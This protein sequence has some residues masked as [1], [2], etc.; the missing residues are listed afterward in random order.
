[1]VADE[2]EHWPE[3]KS[4]RASHVRP[5]SVNLISQST[6]EPLKTSEH[7]SSMHTDCTERDLEGMEAGKEPIV[8]S[9][10]DITPREEKPSAIW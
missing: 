1:M 7:S 6:R 10:R 8:S 5:R 2:D 4:R 9:C 3:A